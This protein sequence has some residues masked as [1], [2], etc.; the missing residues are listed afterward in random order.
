M[1][2]TFQAQQ[3]ASLVKWPARYFMPKGAGKSTPNG[4]DGGR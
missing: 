4:G 1:L 2:R 3:L